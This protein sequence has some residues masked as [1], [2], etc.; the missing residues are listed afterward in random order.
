V[1]AT[2]SSAPLF[3]VP[4]LP[5][6]TPSATS[7][8]PTPAATKVA[9]KAA[10]KTVTPPS[11]D[12]YVSH[13]IGVGSAKQVISVTATG[14][15]TSLATFQAFTKT[16]SGWVRTF[17]PWTSHVGRKGFAPPGQ[18]RQGDLR[19]P[20]GAYGFTY[21]FGVNANPG[22]KYSYRVIDSSAI[23]WNND[24]NSANYNQWVDTRTGADAGTSPEPMYNIP[25]YYYGAVIAYNMPPLP[26]IGS[27]IFLH[28]NSKS[29]GSTAGC[30]SLPQA[31][32][33][34]VLRW[35]DP[36][37]APV[38]VMGPASAVTR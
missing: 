15:G 2:G 17:G 14:Y 3:Q 10:P 16:P 22:V 21:M 31:Q 24:E 12:E 6:P 20:T 33:L 11:A 8:V 5:T 36:A 7:P 25:P 37:A 29:N 18:K 1:T 19:T 35:M 4:P 32:L 27:A 38:I 9:P 34:Q 13:L 26:G 28:Q 30:V 23:V